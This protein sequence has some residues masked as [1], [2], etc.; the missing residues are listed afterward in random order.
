MDVRIWSEGKPAENR[1]MYFSL[2]WQWKRTNISERC[3][4]KVRKL[5]KC[6]RHKVGLETGMDLSAR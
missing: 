4:H 6:P 5:L 2:I 3:C 1:T